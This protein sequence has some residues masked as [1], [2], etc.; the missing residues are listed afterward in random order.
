MSHRPAA[1]TTRRSGASEAASRNKPARP[2]TSP[3]ARPSKQS[4]TTSTTTTRNADRPDSDGPHGIRNHTHDLTHCPKSRVH[5]RSRKEGVQNHANAPLPQ[6]PQYDEAAARTNRTTAS[7]MIQTLCGT[8]ASSLTSYRSAARNH[9]TW[10]RAILPLKDSATSAS[11][12]FTLFQENIARSF[13][14]TVSRCG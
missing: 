14:P 8:S 13:G 5:L 11:A 6:P 4:T 10:V 3:Q 9:C 1:G 7:S 12:S 2:P